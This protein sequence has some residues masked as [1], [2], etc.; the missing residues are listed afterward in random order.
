MASRP[1]LREGAESSRTLEPVSYE[2]AER[3][4]VRARDIT[5]GMGYVNN[6]ISDAI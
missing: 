1:P 6:L 2:L 4:G 3:H 5:Y